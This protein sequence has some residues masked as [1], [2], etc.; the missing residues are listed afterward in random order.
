MTLMPS[1]TRR[2]L[3]AV[4]SLAAA[5]GGAEPAA[6]ASTTL[7]GAYIGTVG[8]HTLRMTLVETSGVVSGVGTLTGTNYGDANGVRALTINGT[9]VAPTLTLTMTT[10]GV[11]ALELVATGS[12]TQF[13]ATLLGYL[14]PTDA[15]PLN[16]Q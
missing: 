4:L 11:S 9:Y 3:L 14:M 7:D 12:P 15:F 2:A 1:L 8:P 6:P 10:P 16:R 13:S 5:C